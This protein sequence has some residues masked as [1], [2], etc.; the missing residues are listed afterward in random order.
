M[1]FDPFSLRLPKRK[2]KKKSLSEHGIRVPA[3]V[4]Q[5][6]FC[7]GEHMKLFIMTR[8]NWSSFHSA[9]S[10]ASKVALIE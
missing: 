6:P 8:S 2:K 3:M 1:F 5:K 10:E 7:L 9:A 4:S